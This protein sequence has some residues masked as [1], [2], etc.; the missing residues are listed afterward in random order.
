MDEFGDFQSANR[1]FLRSVPRSLNSFNMESQRNADAYQ[2]FTNVVRKTGN[3]ISRG[4]NLVGLAPGAADELTR[5]VAYLSESAANK[6]ITGLP[7]TTKHLLQ[8]STSIMQSINTKNEDLVSRGR[9]PL[10]SNIIEL[11]DS[12]YEKILVMVGEFKSKRRTDVSVVQLNQKINEMTLQIVA[13][14]SNILLDITTGR[15]SPKKQM[16]YGG[17]GLGLMRKYG[18]LE[19]RDDLYNALSKTANKENNEALSR[20]MY[21][22]DNITDKAKYAKDI[23]NIALHLTLR[24]G[25][26]ERRVWNLVVARMRRLRKSNVHVSAIYGVIEE[27]QDSGNEALKAMS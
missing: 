10:D 8:L 4:L 23:S 9:D 14:V 26:G 12:A 7:E 6:N 22:L 17:G 20:A 16:F 27:L 1:S 11:I 21:Y 3:L 18:V 24:G 2:R 15:A 5:A 25:L 19:V 13:L